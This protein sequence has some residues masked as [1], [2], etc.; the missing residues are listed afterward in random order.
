MTSLNLYLYEWLEVGGECVPFQS[1]LEQEG[2][3]NMG[4]Q[5]RH[6][7]ASINVYL[8]VA[9]NNKWTEG[10]EI[11]ILRLPACYQWPFQKFSN[12]GNLFFF[13]FS[14]VQPGYKRLSGYYRTIATLIKPGKHL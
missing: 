6:V 1:M 7:F 3:A 9:I 14:Q 13:S 5:Y 2:Y 8:F 12:V 11:N 10:V 4:V